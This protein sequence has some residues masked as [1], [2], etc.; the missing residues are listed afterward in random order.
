ME[1]T[2]I[3]DGTGGQPADGAVLFGIGK[4]DGEG[5]GAAHGKPGDEIVF[6]LFR[7]VE[8]GAELLGQLFR[9]EGV[10]FAAV[11]HVAVAAV[12][13]GGHDHCKAIGGN[14]ALDGG[15]ALPDG[16]VVAHAVEE[17]KRG[18]CS[19]CFSIHADKGVCL[20]RQDNKKVHFHFQSMG[21]GSHFNQCQ[22]DHP[23][24]FA[25]LY[26]SIALC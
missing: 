25:F 4:T 5:T 14:I 2:V 1:R 10:V 22:A 23:F 6:P 13:G 8:H 24:S 11:G 12:L 15:A 3:V 21:I 9:N 7:E 17:I 20:F 16:V 26:Y 18:A 19:N